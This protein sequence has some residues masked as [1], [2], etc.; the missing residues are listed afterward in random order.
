MIKPDIPKKLNHFEQLSFRVQLVNFIT[1]SN[2]FSFNK[3]IRNGSLSSQVSQIGLNVAA[4]VNSVQI[5]VFEG[6]FEGGKE[7]LGLGTIPTQYI[8]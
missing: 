4:I 5:D 8:R 1:S 7:V 3:N 2:M 6:N